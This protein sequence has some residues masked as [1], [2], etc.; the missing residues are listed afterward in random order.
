MKGIIICCFR[1][2]FALKFTISF[3]LCPT[4]WSFDE[5]KNLPT[6]ENILIRYWSIQQQIMRSSI[7][8]KH[9]FVEIVVVCVLT[10]HED[11]ARN[12]PKFNWHWLM[13]T[14]VFFLIYLSIQWNDTS[15]LCLLLGT[16]YEANCMSW[17]ICTRVYLIWIKHFSL[18]TLNNLFQFL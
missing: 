7:L 12:I 10:L 11:V 8:N 1:Q 6:F 15:L 17:R 9:F 5:C 13:L 2:L 3:K 4:F 18:I 16:N 14:L